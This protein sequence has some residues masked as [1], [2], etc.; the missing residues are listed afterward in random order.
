MV[1]TTSVGNAL[2]VIVKLT[3]APGHVPAVGITVMM[4]VSVVVS[5]AAALNT[6]FPVPEAPRPIAALVLVHE[7]IG[8]NVPV[9]LTVIGVPGHTLTFAG[10]VIV[11][12]ALTV[13]VTGVRP[14]EIQP[15]AVSRV[16]E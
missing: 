9:K 4:P 12:V 7:K 15:V 10:V 2:T 3:G 11:G 5:P 6:R 14:L 1:P 16:S 13:S 8:V